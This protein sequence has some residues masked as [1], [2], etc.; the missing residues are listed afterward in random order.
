MFVRILRMYVYVRTE[1]IFGQLDAQQDEPVIWN[2]RDLS[3]LFHDVAPSA[4][5]SVER[6]GEAEAERGENDGGAAE[7]EYEFLWPNA[8]KME[9]VRLAKETLVSPHSQPQ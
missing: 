1:M 4:P 6:E 2:A 8:V 7:A 3:A 9:A 5:D